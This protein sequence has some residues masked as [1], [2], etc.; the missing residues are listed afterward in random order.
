MRIAV[1]ARPLSAPRTGIGRYLAELLQRMLKGSNHQWFLYGPAPAWEKFSP[2]LNGPSAVPPN[3]VVRTPDLLGELHAQVQFPRWVALDRADVFWS[4][5]HRVPVRLPTPAVVT[6]HDLVWKHAPET[7]RPLGYVL[8]RAMMPRSINRANRLIAVS[9]ATK[10]SIQRHFPEAAHK[11]TVVHA[12]SFVS[13]SVIP[14]PQVPRPYGLFVG[15]V[16]PRKNLQRLL[17]AF[18]RIKDDV[19]HDLHLVGGA[20]WRMPKPD[21]LVRAHGLESRVHA[22]GSLEDEDLLAQYAGCDFVAL[23]SLY[24][25]FGLPIIEAMT[26]GKPVLTGNTSSM[27]EIAGDAGLFVDPASIDDIACGLKRMMT[28]ASLRSRLAGAARRRAMDF[29]WD[30]AAAETIRVIESAA[31]A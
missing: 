12:A 2:S 7:M 25:G 15:T 11:T 28:D 3:V 10:C 20:G 29:S 16:E 19:Q 23:P 5:R 31:T 27:P 21:A 22:L 26:F 24:E 6:I 4:P 30:S 17:A 1:D 9:R 14:V 18:T 8:E 13:P